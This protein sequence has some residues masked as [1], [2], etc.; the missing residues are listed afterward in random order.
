MPTCG[1]ELT[2]ELR[3]QPGA[4]SL[5]SPI[6]GCVP[7]PR[8]LVALGVDER[9][10][11]TASRVPSRSP[12]QGSMS[13]PGRSPLN[14]SECTAGSSMASRCRPASLGECPPGGPPVREFF[15][16][17]LGKAG[18]PRKVCG[19]SEARRTHQYWKRSQ[20]RASPSK[21]RTPLGARTLK[22]AVVCG[23][24]VA[25]VFKIVSRSPSG[26]HKGGSP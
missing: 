10:V 23:G 15:G 19:T 4:T 18:A 25:T 20:Y 12:T 2:R 9:L 21:I 5:G 13:Q 16:L 22:T 14:S 24:R 8:M 17:G 1:Y 26:Q 11:N 6:A 7:T 3:W